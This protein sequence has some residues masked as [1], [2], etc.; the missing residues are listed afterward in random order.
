M[1]FE[2]WVVV[3]ESL[4][5][6]V[7]ASDEVVRQSALALARRARARPSDDK[8]CRLRQEQESRSHY[9]SLAL[10]LALS[11]PVNGGE[12]GKEGRMGRKEKRK[13]KDHECAHRGIPIP[14]ND[15]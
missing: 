9:L 12:M 8:S 13:E 2:M 11:L 14:V 15:K 7:F 5:L 10:S 4:S 6:L 3:G 1:G